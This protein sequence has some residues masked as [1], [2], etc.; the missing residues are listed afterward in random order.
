V[1]TAASSG[2]P[3]TQL[4][5]G[6]VIALIGALAGRSWWIERQQRR[7]LEAEVGKLGSETRQSDAA[8]V[9]ELLDG[10]TAMAAWRKEAL[11]DATDRIDAL[12][13]A[14][15]SAEE[16][17]SAC[18]KQGEI[19]ERLEAHVDDLQVRYEQEHSRAERYLRERNDARDELRV[20]RSKLVSAEERIAAL[21]RR[22][23]GTDATPA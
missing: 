14:L 23:G 19:I 13:K 20:V 15:H 1:I 4:L 9:R 11:V 5:I 18:E 16:R 21:E 17:V 22:V 2:G 7:K 12:E 8:T 3:V 6:T 10:A